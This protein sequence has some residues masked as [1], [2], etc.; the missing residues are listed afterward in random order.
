M[1][2]TI[3]FSVSGTPRPQGSK[4]HVGGGRMVEASKHLHPWRNL[5]IDAVKEQAELTD[6]LEGPVSVVIEFRIP[7][8]Q[9]PKHE[10]PISRAAGDIDKL[11]R[12]ILDALTIGGII[13]DDSHVVHLTAFKRY[14]PT[15]PGVTV[16]I[17]PVEV[18]E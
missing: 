9:K 8:P 12:A 7:R 1:T 13:E 4:R 10:L 16:Y 17:E 2:F 11:S 5:V 15:M 14:S 18:P 6:K 3:V